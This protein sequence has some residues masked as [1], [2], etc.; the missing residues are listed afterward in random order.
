M[1]DVCP[2]QR[3][4]MPK[5]NNMSSHGM[6]REGVGLATLSDTHTSWVSASTP[7]T[8]RNDREKTFSPV[9]ERVLPLASSVKLTSSDAPPKYFFGGQIDA[10]VPRLHLDCAI[11]AR[12]VLRADHRPL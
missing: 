9:Y 8:T 11:R 6:R 10:S 3:E 7:L 4:G 1:F 12:S 2:T 5:G